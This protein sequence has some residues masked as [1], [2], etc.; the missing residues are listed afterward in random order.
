MKLTTCCFSGHRQIPPEERS[1]LQRLLERQ[2]EALIEEGI[3]N[4]CTGGALGFDTMAAETVLK[5]KKVYPSLKLFLFLP[6]KD[7]LVRW[8]NPQDIKNYEQIINDA[9]Q[10]SYASDSYT[11]WCMFARNRMLVDHS[12]RCVCYLNKDAGG[13]AYTVNYARKKGLQ[14]INLAEN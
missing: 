13:T 4:F 2:I 12:S 11:R 8:K 14:I 10:V 7:Q 1:N 9:D 6:C 5:F 3:E